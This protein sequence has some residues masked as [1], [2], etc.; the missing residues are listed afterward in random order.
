VLNAPA[1]SGRG[2]YAGVCSNYLAGLE[3]GSEIYAFVSNPNSPFRLPAD[4]SQPI[5]LIGPGTGLAPL[6]GFLQER[7]AQQTRGEKIGPS[8]LFTGCRHPEHDFI[9]ADE[10][11]ALEAAGVTRMYPSFSR[12]P[13]EPKRY[14]QNELEARQDELWSLLES[15]ASVYIC[16]D[17][18]HM[19][20]AVRQ[21]FGRLYSAKTGGDEAAADAW[22]A[23]LTAN[24]RYLADVWAAT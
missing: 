23:Q 11:R 7:A 19:A 20:P 2:A 24:H 12:V 10:L 16:G 21:S 17:A 14:V 5:I 13:G 8:V 3:P 6:R 18:R 4:P 9:Y 1:L 15:G 22:L